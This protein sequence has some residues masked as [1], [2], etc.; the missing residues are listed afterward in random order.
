MSPADRLSAVELRRLVRDVEADVGALSRIHAQ[1]A[2]V[3]QH[4]VAWTPEQ[5]AYLAVRVH[6]W[7]TALESILE[8]VTRTLEGSLPSGPT[9]HRDL[10]RGFTL[11]LPD[12]RPA[13]ISPD[14]LAD[15]ADLLAFRHFFRHS[16][17][18]D[19]DEQRLREHASRLM[20][21][22][23]PVLQDLAAFLDIMR[24]WITH[25]EREG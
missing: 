6:A 14:R 21:V 23:S 13:A 11:P 24:E 5:Q 12:V 22:H 16:Y 2:A 3:V 10:L 19:L 8:R 18:V 4:S 15:L 9:S 25:L 20:R 7:Y 17:A 1:A